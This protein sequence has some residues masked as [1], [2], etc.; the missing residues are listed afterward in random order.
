MIRTAS[1]S[2]RAPRTDLLEGVLIGLALAGFRTLH[3]A[4]R[5]R[6]R[7]EEPTGSTPRRVV[8][9]G[10]LSFLSVPALSR[11]LAAVPPGE[12]VRVDL[13][14]DYLDH[15]AF[16]HL[17]T[18]TRRHRAT[19]TWVEVV[20]EPV[21]AD[22]PG[23]PFPGYATWSHWQ[24]ADH[25]QHRPILAGVAAYHA[26]GAELMR[27]TL[28]GMADGQSPHGL[29]LTCSDSR[30]QPS[31]ITRS[32]PG[33]L[34]TVQNVGN[35]AA[36]TAVDAAVQYATAVLDVPLIAVCGHSACG[37]MRGLLDGA[38]DAGE[39][40]LTEWLRHG[41]P[42]LAALR[43]GHPVGRAALAAGFGEAD[44]L[45]MVNVAVQL[46][47]LRAQHGDRALHGLF[48]H[49]PTARVLVLDEDT[50]EFRPPEQ[51]GAGP[52]REYPG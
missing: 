4:G 10:A 40:A 7:I 45:A 15:A 36:G 39:G 17:H 1:W 3:R 37:A 14:V 46:G 32:G 38:A 48:F 8:V 47:V 31:V 9:E 33:D 35:L 5:A 11:T 26:E 49:I 23:T 13:V 28:R 18:W 6:V 21:T 16:D 30:V 22:G 12:P 19:G 20:S 44:A 25:R 50:H 27:P 43:A 42:S 34:F 51:H 2:A 29:L 41:S 24:E 52:A